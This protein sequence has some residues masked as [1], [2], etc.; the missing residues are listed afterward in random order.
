[1]LQITLVE[2]AFHPTA[3]LTGIPTG[4]G[5]ES[6]LVALAIFNVSPLELALNSKPFVGGLPWRITTPPEAESSWKCAKR[7][8][9]VVGSELAPVM[10]KP[11]ESLIR[12]GRLIP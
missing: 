3:T 7:R 12:A 6:V 1:M 4:I 11:L 5:T 8:K 9:A 2:F 10:V